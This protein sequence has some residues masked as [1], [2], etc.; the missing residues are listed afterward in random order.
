MRRLEASGWDL[1]VTDVTERESSWVIGYQPRKYLETNDI[2][3]VIYGSGPMV[4]GKATGQVVVMDS[5]PPLSTQIVRAERLLGIE[6]ENYSPMRVANIN[7]FGDIARS[8][9]RDAIVEVRPLY[10]QNSAEPINLPENRPLGPRD[11]Y[12]AAFSNSQ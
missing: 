12:V 1:I 7:P 9:L 3:H 10:D 6:G 5:T 11:F 4:I 8:L 2:R